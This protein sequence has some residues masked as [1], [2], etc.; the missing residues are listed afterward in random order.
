MR[1]FR[2]LIPAIAAAVLVSAGP[3]NAVEA[4]PAEALTKKVRVMRGDMFQM[5]NKARRNNSVKP[6]KMNWRVAKGALG[7]SRRMVRRNSIYHNPRLY[8]LVRR[9]RPHIWGENVGMA[10]TIGRM[11]TLFMKS[12]PHRANVLNRSYKRVG[13][14]VQRTHRGVWVT[15]DF[16]G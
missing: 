16:Y 13:V 3:V 15:V 7:H 12:A 1:F 5:I 6:L 11:H 10:G 14:G 8:S 9:Y 2:Y 4:T